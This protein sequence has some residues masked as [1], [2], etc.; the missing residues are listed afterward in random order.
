MEEEKKKVTTAVIEKEAQP[1]TTQVSA[2]NEIFAI[3]KKVV[4]PTF[5]R[6]VLTACYLN[7]TNRRCINVKANVIAGLG[8]RLTDDDSAKSSG[9][10]DFLENLYN[11]DGV[12]KPFPT[13]LKELWSDLETYGESALECLRLSGKIQN[14]MLLS[15]RNLVKDSNRKDIY[16]LD[17]VKN[18]VTTFKRYGKATKDANDILSI[19]FET[20][21]DAYYG[22]P[23]Y[24]S[25]IDSIKT[26]FKINAANSDSLDNIIDPSFLLIVNG[27][28]VPVGEMDDAKEV[29]RG[30][31]NKRSS[32]GIINFGDKDANINVQ[33]VGAG[34]IDGNYQ[35]DKVSISLEVMGLHGLT[36]E[37]YG[38]LSNGGISSGEKATGAL[39]IFLQTVVRPSQQ[40]LERLVTMF[41]RKEF[42]SYK[43]E[44]VLNT[45]DLTDSSE[46]ATTELTNAQ[47][48]QALIATGSLTLFNEY[49]ESKNLKPMT[50]EEW[51]KM[52]SGSTG[53]GLEM[54]KESF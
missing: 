44:F 26:L 3:G 15:G 18:R 38:V 46:D 52:L 50:P 6:E 29:L 31:K 48:Y 11:K 5:D 32:A 42:P 28:P 36:P 41:I 30:L 37:L 43:G 35:Q 45:I 8:Y 34:K 24:V 39:K 10:K 54:I 14:L 21:E 27:Y 20:P 12:P 4:K 25:A 19:S 49:R 7:S 13:L 2:Y 17:R 53:L 23:C 16:Q 51:T 47:T 33:N 40:M 1:S 22:V 9:L